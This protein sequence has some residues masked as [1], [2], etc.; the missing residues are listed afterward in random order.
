MKASWIK[1]GSYALFEKVAVLLF[2]FGGVY[3]LL[4]LLSKEDFGTWVLFLTV[5]AFLE[6]GRIGLIQNA[7]VKHIAAALKKDRAEIISASL[8]LNIIICLF[9][10]LLILVIAFPLSILW[11]ST[12]LVTLMYWYIITSFILILFHH[13]NFVQQAH[14][15]FRG[16]FWSGFYRQ[17]L[18]FAYVLLSYSFEW[19][20]TLEYLG[21]C[22]LISAAIGTLVA[23]LN[24][25]QFSYFYKIINKKWVWKLFHYG[26][27]VLGTNLS[28]MLYKSIDKLM[29]G[30]M[31]S[32]VAVALYD[33]AI[34]I[35]NLVE[36]PTFS[37]A[38]V[39]FPKSAE[40][41]ATEGKPAVKKLYEQSVAIMLA[42]ILPFILIIQLFPAFIIEIIA[43]EQY[44]D[45]V[46]LLRLTILFGLFIPFATQF[47]TVLDSIG[48]P[49]I[50]FYFVILGALS[51]ILF[52]YIFISQFGLIGA[53][54]GT[55]CTYGIFFIINQIVLHHIFKINLF[56]VFFNLIHFYKKMPLLAA[57]FFSEKEVKIKKNTKINQ[58]AHS[59][60]Q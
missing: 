38:S 50:N 25:R 31:L 28:A 41:M 52:N 36:V 27:Y 16:I 23:Y 3:L 14:F 22:L 54:Y 59:H 33:I 58:S 45:A 26:K 13:F 8:F 48:K 37:L 47:G 7:L 21:I 10:V 55:L 46:P 19:P 5:V 53:A 35:T 17:G 57:Q 24:G 42:L 40:K 6:M 15:Y 56:N 1:S 43:G 20:I 39:V 49:K 51:N 60:I 12:E 9:S 32:T 29:L 18:F 4:R 2:S 34:K 30:T 44:L 11:D